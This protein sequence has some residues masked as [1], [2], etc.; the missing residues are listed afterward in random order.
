MSLLNLGRFIVLDEIGT[1]KTGELYGMDWEIKEDGTLLL[2]KEGETQAYNSWKLNKKGEL[3]LSEEDKVKLDNYEFFE[4]GDLKDFK[5]DVKQVV[6]VG[7]IRV[8]GGTLNLFT[9][10]RENLHRSHPKFPNLVF[11]DLELMDISGVKCLDG[12]FFG[13]DKLE[14]LNIS[15][16]D[17]SNVI[18]MAFMFSG[19]SNLR[20]L[21]LSNFNTSNVIDMREMFNGC[22]NLTEL[23]LSN[24]DISKIENTDGIFDGCNNLIGGK[25]VF[26]DSGYTNKLREVVES[27]VYRNVDFE[28]L[29]KHTLTSISGEKN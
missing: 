17:T 18:G 8:E 23:D 10:Y 27:G 16:W 21:D 15:S 1:V 3:F 26:C 20:E 4:F 28:K 12:V 14:T 5:N 9:D 24:F 7:P 6:C 13:C 19:C 29:V 25:G 2:G 22:K 11:A